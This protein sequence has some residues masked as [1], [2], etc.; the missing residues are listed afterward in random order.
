[1]TVISATPEE[2]HSLRPALAKSA[3]YPLKNKLT[4][5]LGEWHK[6]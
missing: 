4:E 5:G 6:W 1:M 3:L 2:D